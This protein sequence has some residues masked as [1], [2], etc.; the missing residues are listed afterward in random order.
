[1]THSFFSKYFKDLY[2]VTPFVCFILGYQCFALFFYRSV[3]ETPPII[4]KTL[5]EA[6]TI[7]SNSNLNMRMIT[8]QEDPDIPAGTIISQTPRAHSAIKP[9]QTVFFVLSKKPAQPR[10]PDV[11]GTTFDHYSKTLRDLKI[12]YRTFLVQSDKTEGT[13]LSQIP[14]AGNEIPTSGAL[15]YIA[16]SESDALLFP[17]CK[18]KSIT[19]VKQFFDK[20]NIPVTI[21]HTHETSDYHT[22]DRCIVLEQKP[23]AGSFVSLKEPFSVQLKV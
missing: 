5:S 1:M 11:R 17:S 9:Q 14:A 20:Y 7:L 10:V 18:G 22:C 23:L 21:Y 8:E 6:T 2:W 13:C 4:G 12:R 19:E 3:I 15:L 16:S